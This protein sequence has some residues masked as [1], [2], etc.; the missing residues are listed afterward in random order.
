M[1]APVRLNPYLIGNFAP[2]RSEDDFASLPIVGEIPKEL[3]GSY[4]RTGPNPQFEP[5]DSNHH[6]FA[7]DGMIH[8]FT[9]A[10]GK[11]SYRNRWVRT[12]KWELEHAAGKALFGT[13][14]NPMTTDPSV[15]GKDSGVANTNIVWHAGRLLALEEGHQ[16]FEMDPRTLESRGYIPY[17]GKANRFTAHP[18]IDPETGELVFFGYMAG[19]GFFSDQVAYGVADKTGR[20]TR[21]DTF[22][23]PYTSMIHDFL[24]TKNHVL[25]PVL[26][27]TGNL[28]RAMSGGPAFAWEPEKGS[29]IGVM[30]RDAGIDTIRWFE[31]GPCYVFHPMNMW[32]EGDKIYAHVMQYE[33]AP[34][35]PNAD[36][37]PG[38][39]ASARL[40]LWT[41]DLAAGTLTRDYVDDTEG[42]FPRLDERRAGLS[43]RHGYFAARSGNGGEMKFDAV[44]HLDF[45]TGKKAMHVLPLG[46]AT[47][48]PVFV[49]RHPSAAEGDGWL[50]AVV[51]R[52]NEDRSDFVVFDAGD[53]AKG[54]VGTAQLPR[55][56]PFGFHGNWMPAAA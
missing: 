31:T 16:P 42:E 34:L 2:V 56:V 12:P 14:G 4:F 50:V 18:K 8:G 26:P 11:V 44:A 45:R 40:A 43:Y 28:Q 27:L 36:G 41:F 21:L 54:P 39:P 13:F 38:K 5:R 6:W 15:L 10:G 7:G 29:H 19:E 23:A 32:E 1:N 48:E 51:Y 53:V 30:R 55:R 20:V 24:V 33:T 49:P 25:F 3:A 17:A 47:G 46:D 22:T 52:G 35:F 37:S 9:V